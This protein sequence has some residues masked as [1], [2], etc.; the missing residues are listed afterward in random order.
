MNYQ[1]VFVL[2]LSKKIEAW[3]LVLLEIWSHHSFSRPS[4]MWWISE[5]RRF[6][7]RTQVFRRKARPIYYKDY[8]WRNI[9]VVWLIDLSRRQSGS[10]SPAQHVFCVCCCQFVWRQRTQLD[11][12][13]QTLSCW[14]GPFIHWLLRAISPLMQWYRDII[15]IPDHSPLIHQPILILVLPSCSHGCSI[16]LYSYVIESVNR[17]QNTLQK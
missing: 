13:Q 5:V 3:G 15:D 4:W 2:S 6:N 8:W 9:S 11:L 12:H 1:L 14:W 10:Q 7:E 16:H 17:W